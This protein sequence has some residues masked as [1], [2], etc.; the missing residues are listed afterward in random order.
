MQGYAE[1]EENKIID[2]L[3]EVMQNDSLEE[4]ETNI[5]GSSIVLFIGIRNSIER[6]TS[7]SN[8]K[9]LLDLHNS[10]RN[11]FRS[12][13]RMLKKKCPNMD[14]PGA[15]SENEEVTLAEIVNTCD[16]CTKM[17]PSLHSLL[18]KEIDELY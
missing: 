5:Y 7:F 6:C 3:D 18:K 11:V 17:I 4:H 9:A 1:S 8:S 14:Q 10:F 13:L 2:S 12:Y 15:L 16:Y